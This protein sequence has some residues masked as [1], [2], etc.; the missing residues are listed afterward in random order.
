MV[1]IKIKTIIEVLSG[2]FIIY[3]SVQAD[4]NQNS[5]WAIDKLHHCNEK[6]IDVNGEDHNCRMW[7]ATSNGI[8]DS[9][10]YNHLIEYPNSLKNLSQS[11]NV[12]GWG[13]AFYP[14]FGDTVIVERGAVRACNDPGYDSVVTQIETSKPKISL[15]HIR[16]CSEGCCC[17]GYD[18]IPDPHPF[19]RNK[20]NKNW[21]F[22]HNGTIDKSLLYDLIGE[23][24]LEENPLNGSDIPECDPTDTSMV[25]DSELYFLYLLKHIEENSWNITDG[26]IEAL[27]ELLLISTDEAMNFILSDGY[28]LWAF[29]KARTLYY[30]DDSQSDYCAVASMYPSES[31]DDWQQVSDYEL[32]ILS[33]DEAPIVTNIGVLLPS[34]TGVVTDEELNAIENVYVFIENTLVSD[35]TDINGEYFLGCLSLGTYDVSFT[36]SYYSDTVVS[37]IEVFA[38]DTT[39]LDVVMKH[40]GTIAGI[41]T[42]EESS[43]IENVYVFTENGVINDTTDI[44]GEYILEHLNLSFHDVSFMHPYYSDTIVSNVEVFADS[45]I[46]LDVIM[47]DPGLIMGVVTNEEFNPIENVNVIAE[48]TPINDTTDSDGEFV[49]DSLDSGTYH[50]SFSHPDYYYTTEAEIEVIPGDTTTV[51]VVMKELPG[52]IAGIVSD[53]SSDP[54][55]G[56]YVIVVNTPINDSTDINGEYSLDSL[57]ARTYDISFSHP[58]YRDTMVTDVAVTPGDTTTLNVVMEELLGLISGTVTDNSGAPIERAYAIAVGTS[59]DDSTDVNGFYSL[60]DLVSGTYDIS[61]SHPHYRDTVVTDVAVTHGDTTILNLLMQE[62]LGVITGVVTNAASGDSIEGVYVFAVGTDVSDSTDENGKYTLDSLEAGTHDVSFSHEDYMDIAVM[63][64]EVIAGDTT[65]LNVEMNM[66]K[67]SI[68]G[69]VTDEAYEQPIDSVYVLAIGTII[70][71]CTDSTGEYSLDSLEVS[72]YGIAFFHLDY[73]DTTVIGV[74]VFP[75]DTTILD[76]IMQLPCDY[77]PGDINSDSNVMGNDVT[78]GVRYFK[79]IGPQPPDSCWNDS[80]SG[81]LYSSGDVNGSCSFTGSDITF[82][83]A[84]FK[85]YNPEILWCPQTPP[86]E[87]PVLGIHRDVTPVD[88][89]K[90]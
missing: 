42:N 22:V 9:V 57:E 16:K 74:E 85:G 5:W 21:S 39:F 58:D 2:L 86:V 69:I 45:I 25:I 76:V 78:Y 15:A 29:C 83:V 32:V 46:L 33:A 11:K 60:D 64:I 71:D 27:V 67:G 26:I 13:I 44:N 14:D 59:T 28:G 34:I 31:Q 65:I 12:D 48:G 87:S 49:L 41:V 50:I 88:L 43:P 51:D 79:G 80:T 52:I 19:W 75:G 17:H 10:I 84:Y 7:A 56:V 6:V 37:E 47:S 54:I 18:S 72:I 68:T 89:P 35:T 77:V 24:Y 20:D 38:G 70:D 3:G 66:L 55:E 23:E 53:D 40:P 30:L 1:K 61:F 4:F 82:L 90:K 62:L 73:R 8:A 63:D 36:H 81:W